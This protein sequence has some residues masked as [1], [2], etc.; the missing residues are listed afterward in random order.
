M[1]GEVLPVITLSRLL[2]WPLEALIRNMACSCR[3]PSAASFLG[4]DSFAGRDDAGDQVAGGFP[5]Q[6]RGWRDDAVQRADRVDSGHEGL[7]SDLGQRVDIGSAVRALESPPE[8]FGRVE[9]GCPAVSECFSV[10]MTCVWHLKQSVENTYLI[11]SRF[12]YNAST[13]LTVPMAEDSDLEKTEEP[14]GRRIEQARER[15]RSPFR[16]LG[17]FLVPVCRGLRPSG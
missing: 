13:K 14:T 10:V 11:F 8:R 2:G 16:E 3:R 12:S 15:V 17:T 9:R 4:V 1:R 6:G 7:L 5:S